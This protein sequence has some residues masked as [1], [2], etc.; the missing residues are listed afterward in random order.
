MKSNP[1]R[2]STAIVIFKEQTIRRTWDNDAWWFS[3]VDVC[4]V[5]S[6]SSDA[7]ESRFEV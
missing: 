7:N 4:G 2:E 5:L 6:E 1:T 3:V